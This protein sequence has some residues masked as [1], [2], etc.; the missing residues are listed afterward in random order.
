MPFS[1][2]LSACPGPCTP[3]PITATTSVFR[4]SCALASGNSSRVTTFSST[5][6]KFS[7]AMLYLFLVCSF[8]FIRP[9]TTILLIACCVTHWCACPATQQ[10]GGSVT[11][12][13]LVNRELNHSRLTFHVSRLLAPQPGYLPSTIFQKNDILVCKSILHFTLNIYC[14]NNLS[15]TCI[16]Y[17]SHYF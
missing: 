8:S 11:L 12:F 4:T 15:S 6:P 7:F 9:A 17:R 5:P 3:Y 16:K 14:R 13:H 2:W 1:R 10:C